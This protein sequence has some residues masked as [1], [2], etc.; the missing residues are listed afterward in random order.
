M[1]ITE[2]LW[3]DVDVEHIARHGVSQGE[4]E[5]LLASHP[6]WRRGPRHL[7]SGRTTVYA[8]GQTDSG[9]YLLVV[10]SPRGGSRAR[11]VTAMD[12]DVKTRR[13]YEK[14]RR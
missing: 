9:R 14:H 5:Q 4:V 3:T 1:R 8:L 7:A 2:I 6:V 12:M 10:L 13:F 11:C